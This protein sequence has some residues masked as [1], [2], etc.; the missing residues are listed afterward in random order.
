MF[1]F[2]GTEPQFSRDSPSIEEFVL[3]DPDRRVAVLEA[4]LGPVELV[5]IRF[6][7]GVH[8]SIRGAVAF[9]R[10]WQASGI[11]AVRAIAVRLS[12]ATVHNLP[13]SAI[14]RYRS[15]SVPEDPARLRPLDTQ[16]PGGKLR[17]LVRDRGPNETTPTAAD[18]L[19]RGHD[20]DQP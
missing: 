6:A 14:G 15:D 4:G 20:V 8:R 2:S 19:E 3:H 18:L 7:A 11:K 10:P 5:V 1:R 12:T 17:I 9:A 13:P 16:R